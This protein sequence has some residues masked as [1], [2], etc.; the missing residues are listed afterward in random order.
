[1]FRKQGLLILIS[2]LLLTFILAAQIMGDRPSGIL[3]TNEAP[4]DILTQPS[5]RPLQSSD[6]D[7]PIKTAVYMSPAE[8]LELRNIKAKFESQYPDTTIELE[9]LSKA[10]AY[11]EWKSAAEVG[12]APD[13]MMLENAWLNEFAVKGYLSPKTDEFFSG[14]LQSQ[15]NDGILS[16]IRWNGYTWGVPQQLDPYVLIWNPQRFGEKGLDHPP[17]N[18]DELME[19]N[20]Q[21]TEPETGKIGLYLAPD[22]PYAFVSLIGSLGGSWLGGEDE[23]TVRVPQNIDALLNELAYGTGEEGAD[24]KADGTEA[25]TGAEGQAERER[26]DGRI[27]LSAVSRSAEDAWTWLRRGDIA[28]LI[29]RASEFLN[30]MDGDLEVNPLPLPSSVRTTGAWM[31]GASFAVSSNSASPERAFQWIQMLGGSEAQLD[32]MKAGG[33]LPANM[34]AY[35]SIAVG[36]QPYLRKIALSVEQAKSLPLSPDAVQKFEKLKAETQK[37]FDGTHTVAQFSEALRQSWKETAQ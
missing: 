30:R 1:M 17:A 4:T 32:M 14:E 34:E 28:M 19:M 26:P 25:L 10:E 18:A 2:L 36:P 27:A 3:Q 13:V 24:G 37:L 7:E 9:N 6:R 33:G 21:L 22:D 5:S 15:Q 31:D 29:A 12:E 23:Q 20:R 16:Q 8:F 11:R 35:R